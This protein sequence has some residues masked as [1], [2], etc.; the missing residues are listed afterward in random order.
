MVK[1]LMIIKISAVT[2]PH[3]LK[4]RYFINIYSKSRCTDRTK[5][6]SKSKMEIISIFP[7]EALCN[8]M[9][10]KLIFS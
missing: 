7:F 8:L 1:M 5:K 4:I 10:E 2:S 9:I 6:A 3:R